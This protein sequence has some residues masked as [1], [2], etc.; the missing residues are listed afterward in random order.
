MTRK[1]AKAIADRERDLQGTPNN[2]ILRSIMTKIAERAKAGNY[3]LFLQRSIPNPVKVWLESPPNKFTV[4]I[5]NN[6]TLIEW[7]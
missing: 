5:N 2:R 7:D 6:T 3:V 4:T 1:Q